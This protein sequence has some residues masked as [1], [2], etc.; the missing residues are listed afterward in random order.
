MHIVY[1]A[2]A[3]EAGVY[4]LEACGFDNIPVEMGLMHTK[5]QFDGIIVSDI[6]I[7][8]CWAV[9][10]TCY[11]SHSAK[12]TKL[13][14]FDPSW[15]QNPELILM[16]LGMVDYIRGPAPHDNFGGVA[17]RGWSGQIR[18]LS[19]LLSFFFLFFLFEK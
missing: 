8:T 6:I 4:V 9:A 1:N 19:H 3:Q 16:K 10:L 2:K 14:D 13:A 11:I 15:S 17:Q 7:I 5:Q 12:H 18:E